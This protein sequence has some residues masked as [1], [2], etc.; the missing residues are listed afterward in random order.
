MVFSGVYMD[1]TEAERQRTQLN[2]RLKQGQISTV[3]YTNAVNALRVTD[4]SGRIWQPDPSGTGWLCWNGST[5]QAAQPPSVTVP[6]RAKDFK[7][8]KSSLMTLGE[9]KTLSKDV[10]LAKRPQKW[11]DLLSILGGVLG[12][13]LWFL[14][15]GI[16]SGREGFDFITPL[17]MIGIPVVLVWFRTDIDQVLLP[18][19]PHRKKVARIILIGLGIATPFLTAWILYNIFNI[20]QYPLM[21][22]NLLVG[23][24]AAYAIIRDPQVAQGKFAKPGAV[25]GMLLVF[26]ALFFSSALVSPVLA[27]DCM[28]DLLN[29][30]DCLRTDGYAEAMAGL[31]ATILSILVNGPIIVQTLLQGA[32]GAAT[33]VQPPAPPAPPQ[34][35]QVG[36]KLTFV[37]ARGESRSAV[38]QADGHWLTDQGTWYDPDYAALLAEGQKIDAANAA[39]RAQVAAEAAAAKAAADAAKKLAAIPAI[40]P[41]TGKKILTPEQQ[42]R[43][44]YLTKLIEA[45]SEEA[46]AWNN[47]ANMLDNAVTGLEWTKYGCDKTIDVLSQ[48]TGPAGKTI[49]KIYKVGTNVGEGLGEGM[50]EGKNYGTHI[51]KGLGK[52]AVDLIG[53]KIVDKGFEKLGTALGDGKAGKVINWINREIKVNPDPM[54]IRIGSRN[55]QIATRALGNAAKGWL[56]GWGPGYGTDAIKDNLIGK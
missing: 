56:K 44:D 26:T 3:S 53:D 37:D 30:Q 41:I 27:D 25:A 15:G 23:T 21:Q 29:A 24:L 39:W 43:R 55:T 42:A 9:F 35:P 5:W 38:L 48:V 40:D 16:R 1:F 54:A 22:L 8:F 32:S 50:A 49:A 47:Y 2:T 20:S 17:L 46:A 6:E 13:I 31:I 52:A 4:Q 33:G 10:P 11:W 28:S 19:Q 14:Y 36:D 18:L 34:G 45:G 12:A 51:A 7:D